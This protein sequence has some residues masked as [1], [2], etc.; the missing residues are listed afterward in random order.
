MHMKGQ[1]AYFTVEA[2]LVL[3]M[4]M[5]AML[6]GIYLFCY[7]YDRC[8]LE[9]DMGSL[10]IWNSA[11]A[12]QNAGETDKIAESIRQRAAQIDRAKYVAWKLTAI[13]VR[14]EKNDLSLSGQGELS[15]PV[16][17]W[18]LWNQDNLWKAQVSYESS[19]LSP[20]FY[21]RQYRKLHGVLQKVP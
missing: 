13:D 14:L 21:I 16:P 15:F 12:A 6:V 1:N 3:P 20:V 11:M 18:N 2:A 9:Q 17:G 19:R 8:L 7:Q 10:L 4:V 5:S